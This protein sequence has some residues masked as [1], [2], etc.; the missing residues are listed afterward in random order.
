MIDLTSNRISHVMSAEEF[1]ATKAELQKVNKQLDFLVKLSPNETEAFY[2]VSDGDKTFI[3]NCVTEMNSAGDLIPPYVKAEEIVKDL[4]CGDQL[5]ELENALSDLLENVKQNR[6]LANY[7]A[8]DGAAVFYHLM[9][10]AARSGSG[11]AKAI[12]DRLQEHHKAKGRRK[13]ATKTDAK[14]NPTEN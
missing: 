12:Y 1:A 4:A 10:T 2:G 7:E 14:S 5:L 11:Q 3:R 8:Y 13:S 9:G 6:R